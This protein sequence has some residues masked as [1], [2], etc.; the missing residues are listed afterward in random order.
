MAEMTRAQAEKRIRGYQSKAMG[1]ALEM[2]TRAELLSQGVIVHRIATPTAM[3]RGRRVFTAQVP[4]DL[5]GCT[6][7][8]RAVIV[9]CKHRTDDH[10]H[11]R[12]PR[13]SDF[14]DH[15]IDAL[16]QWH[17]RGAVAIVA[18]FG[19]NRQICMFPAVMFLGE[20]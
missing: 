2:A 15:Q 6:A 11:P 8:G 16:R 18:F 20:E 5:F 4:G 1:E 13:L 14:E 10:G 9:E 7:D 17:R 3:R 12:R 19:V